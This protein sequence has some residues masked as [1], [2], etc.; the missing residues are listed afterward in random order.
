MTQVEPASAQI[1][2]DAATIADH[3][4]GGALNIETEAGIQLEPGGEDDHNC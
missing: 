2:Q 3:C 4:V 1:E